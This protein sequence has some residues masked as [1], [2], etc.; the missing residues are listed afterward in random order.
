MISYWY[1]CHLSTPKSN[2]EAEAGEP[3]GTHDK[4]KIYNI[5]FV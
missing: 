4:K 5:L 2:V 3:P 1:I